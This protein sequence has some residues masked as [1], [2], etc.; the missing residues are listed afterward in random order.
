[1]AKTL[2]QKAWDEM[3]KYIR[4]RDALG[5]CRT[6]GINLR[7]F[8]RV[9]DVIGKCCTCI[10]TLAWND[11]DAGHFFSRGSGGGSGVYFDERNVA[12]QCKQCNGFEEGCKQEF[13]D[14]LEEKYGP[15]VIEEL[16]IKHHTNLYRPIEIAGL[17]EYYKQEY[18]KLVRQWAAKNDNQKS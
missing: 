10:K 13:H 5:Y 14:Y 4:L 6:H 7:Q 9:R 16:R 2:K 11:M 18:E 8:A 1:M 15:E 3:S 12:L 17:R